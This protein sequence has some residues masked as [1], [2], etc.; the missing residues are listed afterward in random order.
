LLGALHVL[1]L[2][3]EIGGKSSF[4]VASISTA[5]SSPWLRLLRGPC[6]GRGAQDLQ[7]EVGLAR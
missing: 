4:S 2:G 3:S 5:A 6:P 7:V 1:A